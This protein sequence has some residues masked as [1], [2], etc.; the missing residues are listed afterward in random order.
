MK[1]YEKDGLIKTRKQIVIR[2]DGMQTINPTEEM[3]LADGWVEYVPPVAPEPT[4]EELLER[5][6][7]DKRNE[8]MLYDSSDAVNSFSISGMSMWLDKATRAGLKLRFEAEKASG[9]ES[10][11]LWHEGMQFPL[12]IDTAFQMLYA[13]ELYASAC[14]DNTQKH[15]ASVRSL[16]TIEEVEQ[17]D[18]TT[19]YPPKLEF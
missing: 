12:T 1:R 3:I 11:T 15:M 8:L 16:T 2:K 14:Y 6:K 4:E 7:R 5:A 17:Y 19:G 10:T 13:L 18:F 9:A